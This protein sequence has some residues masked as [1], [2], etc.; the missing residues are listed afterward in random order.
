MYRKPS[1]RQL[2]IRRAIVVA[3]MA[4]SVLIILA[5]TVLSI[6]GY[7]LDGENGRLEQG[8]LVQF[9][10]T[11]NAA[12]V[13]I[14]GVSTGSQTSTKRTV[15]AGEQRIEM[16]KAGYHTWNRTI[17]VQ[18]GTLTWLDYTRL[19]PT[20]LTKQTVR[21]YDAVAGTSASPTQQTIVVQP[22]ADQAVFDV[23]DIRS[24]DVKSRQVTIANDLISEQTNEGVTHRFVMVR[25]DEGGRYLLVRHDYRDT[26]E[27][28]VFDTENAAE[29]VN[30]NKSLNIA[31]SDL[32]FASTNGNVLYGLTDG[33]IRRLDL[34][35]GTISRGLVN[36]V[37]SFEMAT[38]SL[39]TYV[40]RESASSQQLV[41]GLYRDGDREPHIL[42]TFGS[43]TKVMVATH[44]Y[45]NNDYI[46]I[47]EGQKVAVFKGRYPGSG[48]SL[49]KTMTTVESFSLP[50]SIDQL[51]FSP[52]G[53]YVT[54][55][56]G[57]TFKTYEV[58]YDNIH[59]SKTS[60]SDQPLAWLDDAHLSVVYDG[61]MTMRDFDGS[62]S[63]AIMPSVAGFDTT[64]SQNGK[65][66]YG[67]NN[68]DG[69][70]RLERVTMILN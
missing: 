55:R 68:T 34:S 46:A 35:G 41:A 3:I 64:L 63:H 5:G 20:T 31:L 56:S 38:T 50:S 33:S 24:Q 32:Q 4:V 8:A 37:T 19:V 14:N 39:F 30:V 48:D 61:S 62:N 47:A 17:S 40:G 67:V 11:P 70:F 21:S 60:G 26:S 27:W 12:A 69:R 51:S 10:S 13:T 28:I 44:R 43:E 45:A 25:W 57:A 59:E 36:N 1:K 66:M 16:S 52:D 53:D 9:N 22:S 54:A 23:I 58:E 18:P 42:R 7:R 15:M 2:I 6:M 49:E 29:S 65:Y